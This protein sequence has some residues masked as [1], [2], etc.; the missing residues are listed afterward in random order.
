LFGYTGGEAIGGH[1]DDLVSQQRGDRAESE[2]YT[3]QGLRGDLATHVTRRTRK[4]GSLVDVE[5]VRCTGVVGGEAVGLTAWITTS[6]MLQQARRD[7]EAA[8]RPRARS[9]R[10]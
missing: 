8:T 4:D 7:A 6:V 9:W 5:T 10:R 1:I 2:V 3:E